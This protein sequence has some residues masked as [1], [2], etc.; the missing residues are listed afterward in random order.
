MIKIKLYE[1]FDNNEFLDNV[2]D[3]FQDLIDDDI[4]SIESIGDSEYCPKDTISLCCNIKRHKDTLSF[5]E[6]YKSCT[7]YFDTITHFKKCLDRLYMENK[8]DVDVNYIFYEDVEY[9]FIELHLSELKTTIGDFWRKMPVS[10]NLKQEIR[11]DKFKFIEFFS[12]PSDTK[13]TI[14]SSGDEDYISV[15]FINSDILEEH[16]D[17]LIKKITSTK[18]EDIDF[19]KVGKNKSEYKIIK[20]KRFSRGGL[21][22]YIEFVVN[23]ELDISL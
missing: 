5:D 7:E 6:F 21:V 23:K 19:T 8:N 18:I 9:N 10:W 11:I 22:N 13:I 16:S 14:T 3:C 17:I 15:F 20:N 1:S 12:L 2:K 4:V